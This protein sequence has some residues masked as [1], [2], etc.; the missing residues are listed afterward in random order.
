M[1]SGNAEAGAVPRVRASASIRSRIAVAGLP[2]AAVLLVAVAIFSITQGAA[3]IPPWTAVLM[4]VDRLP[5]VEVQTDAPASWERILF[6]I[7]LPRVIAAGLV[8]AAL[9]MAGAT[10][11]GVFRNPLADPFLLGVASGAA[12]G[13]GIVI[14]SPLPISSW[15]FGWVPV[16]AFAGALLTVTVVY[17]LA[18]VGAVINNVTL[19]LA[20]VAISAMLSG[21]T[22]FL[23]LTG[24]QRAQPI[25]E[26]MFGGFNTAAWPRIVLA[27]PYIVIGALVIALHARALNVLQLD[28][29]QAAHLG[30]DVGRVKLILLVSA[31]LI[32]ATAVALAGIIGFVGLVVPHAVRLI[33][34]ND[35]RRSLVAT[36]LIGATFLILVDVFSRTVIAP[37]EVPVGVVTSVL[38]GP[39]FLYLMRVRRHA[40]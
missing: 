8:G 7:R 40:L 17:L 22:A 9:A 21:V 37:Q 33:F 25:L 36:A 4:L 35:Y 28:E 12:L 30:V 27:L 39:F 23:L 26:F 15:G 1:S 34:G 38:G 11:Q 13:A 32:A 24:G 3:S 2:L 18:R 5:L 10:Y 6:D 16:C 20:G 14:M 29:E 31:S 19:I